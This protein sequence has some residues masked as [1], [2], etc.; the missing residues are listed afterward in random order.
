MDMP[1]PIMVIWRGSFCRTLT[2]L[3]APSRHPPFCAV[4]TI[5]DAY[6]ASCGCPYESD[7]HAEQIAD[8]ALDMMEAMDSIRARTGVPTLRLRV[9]IHSGPITAGVI[10]AHN[11]RF[12]LFGDTMN[13][14]SRME[15]TCEPDCIQVKILRRFS[16][17]LL[18]SPSQAP[19]PLSTA[20]TLTLIT[21]THTHS[22]TRAN[23][24]YR[25]PGTSC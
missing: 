4:E 2:P 14:A 8:Q 22:P 10:R 24:R 20:L 7:T 11:R 13:T 12:Q 18:L 25:R 17:G 21:H 15:S 23:A 16:L 5:G 19:L 1:L 3:Y 6:V 9:G